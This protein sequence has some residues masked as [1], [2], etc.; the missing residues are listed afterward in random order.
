M[1]SPVYFPLVGPANR[2]A[3]PPPSP[4]WPGVSGAQE[5]AI[6]MCL[7]AGSGFQKAPGRRTGEAPSLN[8]SSSN[9]KNK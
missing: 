3:D 1:Q 2:I 4:A 9:E 5:E 6:E 7:R 8:W